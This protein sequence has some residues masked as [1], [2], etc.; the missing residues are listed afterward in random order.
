M[1]GDASGGLYF[2]Q[3]AWSLETSIEWSFKKYLALYCGFEMTSEFGQWDYHT[4]IDGLEARTTDNDRDV[5]WFILKPGLVVKTPALLRNRDGDIR[6]WLQAK[7]GLSFAC[8]VSNSV[9]FELIRY[10]AN[11]GKVVGHH[12]IG[13]E[14]LQWFYWQ[15]PFSMTVAFDRFICSLGYELSNFDYYSC[16]RNV[17]LPAGHKYPVPKRRISQ[18]VF[19]AIGYN[20]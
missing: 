5:K 13:N 20:F 15:C 19:L 11:V 7:P 6:F 8:P 1:D 16:R 3:T 12:R 2:D 9:T 10:Q 4:V 18:K 14:G 17:M